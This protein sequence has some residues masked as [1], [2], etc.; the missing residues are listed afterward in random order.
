MERKAIL[1]SLNGEKWEKSYKYP[2]NFENLKEMAKKKFNI[3]DI[4]NYKFTEYELRREIEDQEDFELMTR[5]LSNNSQ[6]KILVDKKEKIIEKNE[7][8]DNLINNSNNNNNKNKIENTI[9]KDNINNESNIN[10]INSKNE[11][12]DNN[13]IEN[14]L[15]ELLEQIKHLDDKSLDILSEAIDEEIVARKNKKKRK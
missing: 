10:I 12:K 2:N 3:N 5:H 8:K 7:V 9:E 1:L 15:S 6:V 13:I 4:E 11:I 14:P